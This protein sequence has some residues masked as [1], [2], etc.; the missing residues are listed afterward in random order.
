ME[1]AAAASRR[2][3]PP[4]HQWRDR[5]HHWPGCTPTLPRAR[6]LQALDVLELILSAGMTLFALDLGGCGLSEGEYISLGWYE[7]EDV[8]EV[9]K[10]LRGTGEVSCIGLWGRSMGAVTSLLHGDRVR[11][12]HPRSDPLS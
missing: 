4:T 6:C 9:V 1:T 11:P 2:D 5:T 7:R 10:H 3:R 8:C 12:T